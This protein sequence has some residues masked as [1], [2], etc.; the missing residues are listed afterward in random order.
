M[1]SSDLTEPTE[2][3]A[4]KQG[5]PPAQLYDMHGDPGERTN[6][7]GQQPDVVDQL[8]RLLESYVAA[9]RSTPGPA[10]KNEVTVNLHKAIGDSKLGSD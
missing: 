5:L 7:S 3:T 6:L 10:Q 9:G 1:C 8:T 4:A 2:A